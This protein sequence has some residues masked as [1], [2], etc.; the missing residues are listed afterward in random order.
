MEIIRAQKMGFCFGV[1]QA[2]DVCNKYSA[3]VLS[4]KN[5]YILGMIVHNEQV[6][7]KFEELGFKTITEDDVM[8]EKINFVSNDIV[9]IRAHGTKK[10]IYDKLAKKKVKIED[11]ACIFVKDIRNKLLEVV[12]RGDEI[13]F[14]GDK[15]H[16]EVQGL[17]SFGDKINIFKDLDELKKFNINMDKNYSVLTQTTLNKDRMEEIKKYLKDNFSRVTIYDKICGATQERQEAVKKIA[18]DSDVVLIV[19]GKKSSNTKKLY[20]ISIA[21]NPNTKLLNDETDLDMTWFHGV[22]KVGITAGA[23]TPKEVIKKIESIIKEEHQ[24]Q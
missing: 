17:V 7:S 10:E 1:K 18:K 5:I 4:G 13:I 21:I 14:I 16:Q 19:G 22:K 11:A 15:D 9:I 8:L 20:E 24:C 3:E 6:V 12:K 23:S 2:I